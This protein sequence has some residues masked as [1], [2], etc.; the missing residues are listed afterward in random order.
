MAVLRYPS[1]SQATMALDVSIILSQNGL[2]KL[3][4]PPA[5]VTKQLNSTMV[6]LV[7]S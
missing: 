3:I 5:T 4:T 6:S 7:F 2:Q 1:A